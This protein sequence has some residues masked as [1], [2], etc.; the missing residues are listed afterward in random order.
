MGTSVSPCPARRPAG[1]P[2]DRRAPAGAR[3]ARVSRR[4]PS[5]PPAGWTPT[6][7]RTRVVQ[8]KHSNRDRT[9]PF[10]SPPGKPRGSQRSV[11]PRLRPHLRGDCS[12]FLTMCGLGLLEHDVGGVLVLIH[13][14]ALPGCEWG[15]RPPPARPARTT[16]GTAPPR[17]PRPARYDNQVWGLGFR[18]KG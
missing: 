2:P 6:A 8:I 14:P 4:P 17:T 15:R 5:T 12:Y 1:C 18:V 16:A 11:W 9:C 10:D 7:P 3:A 13:P